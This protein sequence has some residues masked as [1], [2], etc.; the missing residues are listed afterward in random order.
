MIISLAAVAAEL[1]AGIRSPKNTDFDGR[2]KLNPLNLGQLRKQ[3]KELRDGWK[4]GDSASL[5]RVSVLPDAIRLQRKRPQLSEAQHVLAI[6]HGH[7]NWAGL[8]R[9]VVSQSITRAAQLSGNAASPDSGKRTLHIAADGLSTGLALAGFTGDY[10]FLPFPLDLV[11]LRGLPDPKH[12]EEFYEAYHLRDRAVWGPFMQLNGVAAE[13]ELDRDYQLEKARMDV[14]KTARSYERV[15]IWSGPNSPA[16]K[17]LAFLLSYF[18]E[19]Q[20]RP[21]SLELV[22]LRNFP[23]IELFVTIL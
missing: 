19:P 6:E 15:C 21:A 8:K 3:A 16:I 14:L 1:T 13:A 10:L 7:H 12:P 4:S 5:S 11:P 20:N 22:S 2:L 18:D 17:S 23:G 9:F